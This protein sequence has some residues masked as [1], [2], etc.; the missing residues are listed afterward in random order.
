MNSPERWS[1]PTRGVPRSRGARICRAHTPGRADIAAH[2]QQWQVAPRDTR[3]GRDRQG[4]CASRTYARGGGSSGG[5]LSDAGAAATSTGSATRT[6]V[7]VGARA[8][9]TDGRAAS[10]HGAM[11]RHPPGAHGNRHGLWSSPCRAGGAVASAARLP[12][13]HM[14]PRSESCPQEGGVRARGRPARRIPR[15]VAARGDPRQHAEPGHGPTRHSDEFTHRKAGGTGRALA[16]RADHP[17]DPH[18]LDYACAR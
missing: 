17:T 12:A 7:A 2:P 10:A 11:S 9:T 6:G 8:V 18:A 14:R 16:G 3:P 13:A 1:N 5:R 4:T 15:P